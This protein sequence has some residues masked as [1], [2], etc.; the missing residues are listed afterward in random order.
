M[1]YLLGGSLEQDLWVVAKVTV[2]SH[3]P[4]KSE[5]GASAE[6]MSTRHGQDRARVT[7]ATFTASAWLPAV[8]SLAGRLLLD[9]CDRLKEKAPGCGTGFGSSGK[10]VEAPGP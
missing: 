5:R 1:A 2:V 10:E 6:G 8:R 9:V 7:T 3:N 4:C